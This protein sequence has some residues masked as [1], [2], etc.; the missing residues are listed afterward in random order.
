MIDDLWA[1]AD[2]MPQH[3]R[4]VEAQNGS[5]SSCRPAAYSALNLGRESDDEELPNRSESNLWD[6]QT[7]R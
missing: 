5:S 3:W 4:V 7:P 2:F 6:R 1:L